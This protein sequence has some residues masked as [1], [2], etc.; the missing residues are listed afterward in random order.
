MEQ[1]KIREIANSCLQKLGE[2]KKKT[3]KSKEENNDKK[4]RQ[5]IKKTITCIINLSLKTD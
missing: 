3:Q 5:D 2:I 4:G 1:E